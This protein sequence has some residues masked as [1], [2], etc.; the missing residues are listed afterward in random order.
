MKIFYLP[1]LGE[2]L[3]EAEIREWLVKEGDEVKADQPMVSMETAKAIVEVPAPRGGKII[4]LYGKAG[5]LISTGAPLVEFEDG[6]HIESGT[7]A[8]SLEVGNSV[9]EENATGIKPAL[10]SASSNVKALPV[11]RALAK[12]L[13]VDLTTIMPT[14]ANGQITT[15]DVEKAAQL[16]A[17]PNLEGYE[18]LHGVRRTMAM[19]IAQAHREIATVTLNDDAVLKGNCLNDITL[20]I[21]HAVL[22]ACKTEPS[23]NAWFDGKT[24]SRRLWDEVNL[25]LAMDSTEGLFVPVLKNVGQMS[26]ATVRERINQFKEAVKHRTIA[27][28]DMHGATIVLSNFGTFAGRYANPIIM[29]P[30]VAILG[31]GRLREQPYVSD[32]QIIVQ[33]ILPLSLSFDHRAITGGEAARFLA[34]VIENLESYEKY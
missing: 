31:T 9:L 14:G 33:N 32:G 15:E 30:T 6:D 25:G 2:G 20:C 12:R 19:G 7:V 10:R 11:V 28:E 22:A 17:K 27:A 29:P 18:L 23:L 21:I 3:P 5:E 1:D 26:P 8:G 16:T 13:N 24:I 4:K 34:A